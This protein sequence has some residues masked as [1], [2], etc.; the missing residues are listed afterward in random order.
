M[1]IPVD[2]KYVI[3]TK[4]EVDSVD[5]SKVVTESKDTLRYTVDG[6]K[7]FDRYD[8][9]QPDFISG[10]PELSRSEMRALLND[11]NGEWWKE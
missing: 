11:E 3:I 5:F 6:S 1:G 7:T 10:K 4:D 8:G 9:E 2:R